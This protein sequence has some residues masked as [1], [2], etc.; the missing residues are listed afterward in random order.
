MGAR[1]LY[2]ILTDP[3]FAVNHMETKEKNAKKGQNLNTIRAITDRQ[4][5][6]EL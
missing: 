2:W 3:S 6:S 5:E 4:Y 1:L